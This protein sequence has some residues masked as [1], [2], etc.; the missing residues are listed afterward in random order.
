[1]ELFSRDRKLFSLKATVLNEPF[2]KW[3]SRQDRSH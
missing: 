2:T 1:M 3:S